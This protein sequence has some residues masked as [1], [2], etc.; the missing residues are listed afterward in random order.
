MLVFTLSAASWLSLRCLLMLC[1]SSFIFSW[2]SLFCSLILFASVLFP[3][4]IQMDKCKNWL[5][6]ITQST[7]LSASSG[8]I[9]R[10]T[11]ESEMMSSYNE[12][13]E[14][15]SNSLHNLNLKTHLLKTFLRGDLK[16]KV[17]KQ[18]RY[19]PWALCPEPWSPPSAWTDPPGLY[20][21]PPTS[22]EKSR[23]S[24]GKWERT[25]F[26]T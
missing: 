3:W 8:I 26:Y 7:Y 11:A 22:P 9:D 4:N 24:E 16:T 20:A 5:Q 17:L 2:N 14:V 18:K 25:L 6:L 21:H 13:C 23:N 12:S 19:L 10:H 15:L 1:S